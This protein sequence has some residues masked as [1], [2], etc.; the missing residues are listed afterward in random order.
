MLSCDRVG[1]QNK[2][3]ENYA[4][5]WLAIPDAIIRLQKANTA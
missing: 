4:N 1:L 3:V 5:T 2:I